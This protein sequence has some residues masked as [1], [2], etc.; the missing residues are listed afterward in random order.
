MK[1]ILILGAGFGGL[2]AATQIAKKLRRFGLAEKYEVVLIDRNEHHTYTPLLYE[3]ATTSKT[4]ADLCRLHEVAAYPIRNLTNGL[5]I[6]FVKGEVIKMDIE[7]GEVRL[8]D[9]KKIS[10]DYLVLALGSETNFFGVKGLEES[11]LPLKQFI[12]AVKIRDCVWNLAMGGKEK[13]SIIVGGGGSTG[14]EIAGELKSWCGELDEDFPKCRLE[15]TL[16][17]A[18]QSILAG[19]PAKVIKKIESRLK[20][21]NIE[22]IAGKRITEATK[23]E[24][25]LNGGRKIPFDLFVWAGGVKAPS[26]VS[27]IPIEIDARGRAMAKEDLCLKAKHGFK[28]RASIYGIG[29]I[30]CFYNPTTGKPIPGVARAAISQ[31]NIAT[32]NLIEEIKMEEY[33]AEVASGGKTYKLKLKTYKPMDYPY[34]IPV[35]GKWALAKIGPLVISGF[36]GWVLKGLVEL[37]Y[38]ISIMP[39]WHAIRIWLRGLKIF[40]KNDRLG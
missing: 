20:K 33:S 31:A 9:N 18:G 22:I 25:V 6:K 23:K 16:I 30:I 28:L 38:L 36:F 5:R 40:I 35:G 27:T 12:D 34:V 11:A 37:N 29:D 15:T 13:I 24:V 7:E 4:T 39:F 1:R 17:E 3:I 32:H 10:C 14:V 2:R 8:A 26:I 21:L 19:F